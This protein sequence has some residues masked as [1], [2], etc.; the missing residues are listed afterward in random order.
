MNGEKSNQLFDDALYAPEIHLINGHVPV[1][2]EAK[3]PAETI[4]E[5]VAGKVPLNG[6]DP[7]V[8]RAVYRLAYGDAL[9]SVLDTDGKELIA[10]PT[11]PQK[12][13]TRVRGGKR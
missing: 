12:P 7:E 5:Y 10:Q 11:T 4:Y 6:T 13:R 8:V 9:K 3:P 2:S 1:D